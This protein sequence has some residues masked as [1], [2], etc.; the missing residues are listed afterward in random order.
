M[1]VPPPRSFDIAARACDNMKAGCD[2]SWDSISGAFDSA[3]S[4]SR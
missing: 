1:A 3:M 2:K 4:R